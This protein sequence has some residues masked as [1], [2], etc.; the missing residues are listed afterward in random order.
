MHAD[1]E[2]QLAAG[3]FNHLCMLLDPRVYAV[4]GRCGPALHHARRCLDLAIEHD[5]GAFDVGAAHEARA[6]AESAVII[7]A[8]D[9]TILEGDLADWPK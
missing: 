1:E 7:D 6:R 4:L 8:D 5:L 9:R 3:L 2:R